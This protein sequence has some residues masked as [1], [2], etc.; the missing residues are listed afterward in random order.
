MTND[1]QN[2]PPTWMNRAVDWVRNFIQHP[3]V[4]VVAG[5]TVGI[6]VL[7]L[8]TNRRQP[9]PETKAILRRGRH[10]ARRGAHVHIDLAGYARPPVLNGSIPDVHADY[11][12]GYVVVEEIENDRSVGSTHARR[13]DGN[14]SRW[15][16][17]SKRR[18]YKQIVVKNGRGGRG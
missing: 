5:V 14:F 12:D 18:A 1:P 4:K 7:A 13:Q 16:A 11:G 10:H 3:E 17:R 15:A 2:P 6:G 8:L 9:D